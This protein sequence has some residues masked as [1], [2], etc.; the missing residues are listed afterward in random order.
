MRRPGPPRGRPRSSEPPVG[1]AGVLRAALQVFE[2]VG[3]EAATVRSIGAEA[4]VSAAALYI[5]FDGKEGLVLA[6]CELKV[7]ALK[8]RLGALE[9]EA[10]GP[11]GH[12]FAI[13][14][15]TTAWALQNLDVYELLL[16]GTGAQGSGKI[17]TLG[18]EL[19]AA[20]L[21][22]LEIALVGF[23]GRSPDDCARI[24]TGARALW[25][26][27]NGVICLCRRLDCP[28]AIGPLL[29]AAVAPVLREIVTAEVD[30]VGAATPHRASS[31]H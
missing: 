16:A 11:M 22:E 13:L 8:A 18:R 1:R 23:I 19:D 24:E 5:Y 21:R 4:G 20:C 15:T 27:A 17:W 30:T 28:G 31:V 2:Q 12:A 9:H 10:S 14:E 6:A 25:A 3:F 29:S 26:V 7:T